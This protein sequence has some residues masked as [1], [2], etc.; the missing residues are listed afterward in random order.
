MFLFRERILFGTNFQ[1]E[2]EASNPV[3][4]TLTS[5]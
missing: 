3:K 2:T 1:N 4:S 5:K